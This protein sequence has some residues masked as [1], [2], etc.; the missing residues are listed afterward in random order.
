MDKLVFV[1]M[2]NGGIAREVEFPLHQDTSSTDNVSVLVTELLNT[3]SQHV[4]KSDNLKDGD[5]LQALSM[6]CAIRCG[7]V[8][9]DID[10]SRE[11]FTELFENN[12]QAFADSRQI[13][14][15]RA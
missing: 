1:T 13:L 4:D 7:M 11:L 15:G 5:I 9:V 2:T 12:L 8:N 10:L 3:I 6:V 14:S